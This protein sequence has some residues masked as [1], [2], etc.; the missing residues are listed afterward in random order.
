MNFRGRGLAGFLGVV[1]LAW[2]AIFLEE[3]KS[4]KVGSN[5]P[6]IRVITSIHWPYKYVT[7]VFSP[8]HDGVVTCCNHTYNQYQGGPPTSYQW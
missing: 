6:G 7:G 1:D 3:G 4:H 5:N 8:L 2:L